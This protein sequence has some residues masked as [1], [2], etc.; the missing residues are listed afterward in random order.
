MP[1]HGPNFPQKHGVIPPGIESGVVPEQIEKVMQKVQDILKPGTPYTALGGAYIPSISRILTEGVLSR[2]QY[3]SSLK[4]WAVQTKKT[5]QRLAS[6]PVDAGTRNFRDIETLGVFVNL[7]ESG[8]EKIHP[9]IGSEIYE[10]IILILNLTDYKKL[11]SKG[12][13]GRYDQGKVPVAKTI[14]STAIDGSHQRTLGYFVS[15]MIPPKNFA[16]IINTGRFGYFYLSVLKRAMIE[17]DRLLPVYDIRGNLLWPKRMEHD[18][19]KK[20]VAERESDN[21]TERSKN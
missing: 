4:D 17:S 19:V 21:G 12:I 16:G 7:V 3:T 11:D 9:Y 14:E 2:G 10:Q 8:D 5:R 6:G 20:F 13:Y 1:E 15:Y 18:E